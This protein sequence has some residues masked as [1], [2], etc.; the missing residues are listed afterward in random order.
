V[1]L[2]LAVRG[3]VLAHRGA[4]TRAEECLADARI[5]LPK[6]DQHSL[7]T[8]ATVAGQLAQLRG[9]S[10]RARA[11]LDRAGPVNYLG[12]LTISLQITTS[13]DGDEPDRPARIARDVTAVAGPWA[14]ALTRRM[15]G[16]QNGDPVALADA[17]DRLA[18][19]GMPYESA[20]V[21]LECAESLRTLEN[22]TVEAVRRANDALTAFER[23][24]AAPAADRARRLLRRLGHRP[25]PGR[26]AGGS[27]SD[28]E[29]QVA[30]LVAQGLSNS[31]VAA[32][33]FISHRTVTTHLE[34]IYRRLGFSSRAEL[35]R[36]VAASADPGLRTA[37]DTGSVATRTD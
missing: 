15:E 19:L 5:Q 1:A 9:D 34:R 13:A 20:L 14:L 17:T 33:L 6:G 16:L 37:T 22:R 7:S 32:R 11:L 25:P 36:Y 35:S 2:A 24:G 26:P 3:L 29:R 21:A 30:E 12:L 4:L 8:L 28:R 23:L 31:D 27:L 18:D 10:G